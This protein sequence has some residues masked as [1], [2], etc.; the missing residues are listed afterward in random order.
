MRVLS[1]PLKRKEYLFDKSDFF[2]KFILNVYLLIYQ[3]LFLNVEKTSIF[4][5]MYNVATFSCYNDRYS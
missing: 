5:C 2:K 3:N 1:T 4:E